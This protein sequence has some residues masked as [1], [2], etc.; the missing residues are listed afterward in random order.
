[1]YFLGIDIGTFSSKGVLVGEDGRVKARASVP[2]TMENPA[3]GYF[4]Q[5]AEQIW[6]GD[7]C[8]LS[9]ELIQTSDISPEEIGAVGASTLGADCLPVDEEGKPLRKAILYGIDAR[10]TEEMEE[11]TSYYGEERVQELF[12]RPICSGDVAAKILWLKKNEPEVYKK[13]CKFLTGSSYVTAKL[14]GNYTVDRFLGI[15]SFRPFY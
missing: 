7:F 14:T 12:G 2:H 4:E 13:A 5:D 6:W 11:M 9:K 1:M 15:A 8:K 3:P 10:C